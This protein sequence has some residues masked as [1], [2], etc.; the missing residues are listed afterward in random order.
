MRAVCAMTSQID[1]S[2]RLN[3]EIGAWEDLWPEVMEAPS[4]RWEFPKDLGRLA[5][6]RIQP[7]SVAADPGQIPP[8][9][10]YRG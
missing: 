10:R 4:G 5:R 1:A 9:P 8:F 7:P 2:S 3:S 6:G